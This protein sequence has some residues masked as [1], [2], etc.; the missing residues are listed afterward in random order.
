MRTPEGK[1]VVEFLV[2]G[3]EYVGG[4]RAPRRPVSPRT[5]SRRPASSP[6]IRS[7]LPSELEETR[8]PLA[9]R[10]ARAISGYPD[11]RRGALLVRAPAADAPAH[12][13]RRRRAPPGF[14]LAALAR[15]TLLDRAVARLA[16]EDRDGVEAADR[17][18]R[19]RGARRGRGGPRRRRGGARARSRRRAAYL[20]L[21]LE[22]LAG[23]DDGARRRG[24]RR[25]AGE[26]DLPGGVRARARAR[27][28]ARADLRRRAG[29]AARFGAPLDE[30]L[31]A[32][33]ARRP[34][35]FPGLEAPRR[36]VGHRRRRG[37]RAAPLPHRRR[38]S[39][40]PRGPSIG[41]RRGLRGTAN[42]RA[43]LDARPPAV[44]RW[45]PP[46]SAAAT[47]RPRRTA[48]PRIMNFNAGPAALPLAALE[49]AKRGAHRLRRQRHVGDGAQ[50]PRQG[51]R[52]GPRRGD[53]AAARAARRS[54]TRTR[55]SSSRAAPRSCSRRSR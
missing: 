24:A 39:R 36:G 27:R 11:A 50:P 3:V 8:A 1:Y 30:A 45:P 32:L 29:E 51:V 34:R 55:C 17:R 6:R 37:P 4:P 10:A 40:A 21:G 7:D 41:S 33:A 22:R 5:R 2:D 49:R 26:A 42:A 38:S 16:P 47:P 18:G 12:P 20:E 13:R 28:G 54:P 46:V 35:Y 48:M 52:E 19:E 23:G 15:G 43:R 44:V 25:D 9:H 31:A 53:R 14:F